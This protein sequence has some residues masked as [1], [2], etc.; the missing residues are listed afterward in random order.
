MNGLYI[1]PLPG[2]GFDDAKSE[3][4]LT[5]L[6][7]VA[8]VP[9]GGYVGG[10]VVVGGAL[11]AVTAEYVLVGGV[12]KAVTG[13]SVCVGGAWKT[14]VGAGGGGPDVTPDPVN[15]IGVGYD[16]STGIYTYTQQ[17]I[18]GIDAAITLQV[19]YYNNI[20]GLPIPPPSGA[21]VQVSVDNTAI[22]PNTSLPPNAQVVGSFAAITAEQTFVVT[23]GQYVTFGCQTSSGNGN[24]DVTVTV[25]NVTDGN[26]VMDTFEQ[27]IINNS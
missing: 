1:A 5:P 27:D 11:K 21:R 13:K 22:S 7:G 8:V 20:L 24:M 15:W 4:G 3:L 19:F 10:H 26:A 23:N 18:T 14:L 9:P 16:D 12:W 25:Q 2:Q 6:V 17:Q